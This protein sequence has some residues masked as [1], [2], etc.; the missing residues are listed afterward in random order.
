VKYSV[1]ESQLVA[2]RSSR[3][4]IHSSAGG[5]R[6][7][8]RLRAARERFDLA[9]PDDL[10]RDPRSVRLFDVLASR[11]FRRELSELGYDAEHSGEQLCTL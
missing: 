9:L 2:P 4:T 11:S 1:R 7:R 3:P 10:A 6:V 8:P 5:D